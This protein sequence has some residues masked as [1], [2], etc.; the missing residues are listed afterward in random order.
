MVDCFTLCL[1]QLREGKTLPIELSLDPHELEIGDEELTFISKIIV[2][3][4]AYLAEDHLVIQLDL[5]GQSQLPCS[6]CNQ[7]VKNSFNLK[8]VYITKPLLEIKGGRFS[9]KE[10]LREAIL[11]ETPSFVECNDGHCPERESIQPY[12]KTTSSSSEVKKD[13][14]YYPFGNLEDQLKKK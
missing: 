8:N 10:D 4:G 14:T 6:I 5:Q 9:F 7:P 13:N 2:D 1:E 11:L 12:L 3:G